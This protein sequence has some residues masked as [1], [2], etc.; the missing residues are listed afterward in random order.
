MVRNMQEVRSFAWNGPDP[1]PYRN[2]TGPSPMRKRKSV[3]G[4]CRRS[5]PPWYCAYRCNWFAVT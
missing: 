2:K 3:Y 5:S 1:T 4:F